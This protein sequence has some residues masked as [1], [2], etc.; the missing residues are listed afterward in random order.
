[1]R[2]H[3]THQDFFV[4]KKK[5]SEQFQSESTGPGNKWRAHSSLTR[6]ADT[7]KM[8]DE[9]QPKQHISEKQQSCIVWGCGSSRRV[10]KPRECRMRRTDTTH[11]AS[12][13][14]N[15]FSFCGYTSVIC[16]ASR[17]DTAQAVCKGAYSYSR[18]LSHC[19]N[20]HIKSQ[21]FNAGFFPPNSLTLWWYYGLQMVKIP[22]FLA[23][24]C[25]ETSS[26]AGLFAHTGFHKEPNLSP[27]RLVKVWVFSGCPFHT[28]SWCCS[29]WTSSQVEC[30]SGVFLSIPQFSQPPSQLVWQ[31]LLPEIYNKGLLTE[32]NDPDEIQH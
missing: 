23:I 29:R 15:N 28:R 21:A 5:K 22:K 1:M 10:H 2:L 9:W 14:S 4:K 26:T 27:S 13:R 12:V 7:V 19:S 6:P 3:F 11:W 8:S 24:V 31:V 18:T 17:A 20:S 25:W 30:S 32:I 16:Q